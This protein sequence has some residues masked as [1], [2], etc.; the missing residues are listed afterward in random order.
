MRQCPEQNEETARKS[1][2]SA[3]AIPTTAPPTTTD[4]SDVN[5]DT[6]TGEERLEEAE[7]T[8]KERR[9]KKRRNK[10]RKEKSGKENNAGGH[11]RKGRKTCWTARTKNKNKENKTCPFIDFLPLRY[12][13]RPRTMTIN[14]T[15]IGLYARDLRF[16]DQRT[17]PVLRC[18]FFLSVCLR[19]P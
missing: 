11:T 18:L 9:R 8:K 19:M 5:I 2:A 16:C 3:V 10:R 14:I 1:Y 6:S 4:E 17:M 13:L 12:M 15:L 7:T